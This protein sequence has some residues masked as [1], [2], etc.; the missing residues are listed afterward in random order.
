MQY[1][2]RHT[3]AAKAVI[4]NGTA[5]SGVVDLEGYVL[6]ALTMPSAFTGTALSFVSVADDGT[7]TNVY[8]DA[9]AEV[10][11]TV[12]TSRT[13]VNKTILEQL[14]ALRRVKIRSGTS[15]TPSN[16]AGDRTIT[17]LLKS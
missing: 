12:T 6:S 1:T 5:L 2:V 14:A 4:A 7:E 15:G 3:T 8:D 10:T 16:E 13:Y 11:F 9:G 17:L